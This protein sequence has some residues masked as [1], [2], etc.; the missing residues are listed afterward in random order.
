MKKLFVVIMFALCSFAYSSTV[1]KVFG[2]VFYK[3][4]GEKVKVGDEAK[5]RKDYVGSGRLVLDNGKVVPV[6]KKIGEVGSR[7]ENNKAPV[8]TASSRA[9][10]A[11]EDL[12]WEED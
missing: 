10:S 1:E 6:V 12:D 5:D 11:K 3:E 8:S 7:V 9:S 2:N 4:S